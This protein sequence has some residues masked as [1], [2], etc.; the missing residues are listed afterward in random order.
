MCRSEIRVTEKS[1]AAAHNVIDRLMR[2]AKAIAS[3][4]KT[5]GEVAAEKLN[6]T[7]ICSVAQACIINLPGKVRWQRPQI[8]I[9]KSPNKNGT[10]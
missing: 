9:A 3:P 4:G 1:E 7:A 6:R 5:S 10:P 8:L 2:F